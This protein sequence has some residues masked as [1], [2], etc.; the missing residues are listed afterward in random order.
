M[1]K[2]TVTFEK[3]DAVGGKCQAF[4]ESGGFSP[5]GALWFSPPTYREFMKI[6]KKSGVT[7]IPFNLGEKFEYSTADGSLWPRPAPPPAFNALFM[8]EIR[9]Y[10]HWWN[11]YFYLFNTA[12]SYRY[13][14]P[15]MTVELLK[16]QQRRELPLVGESSEELTK[17]LDD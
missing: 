14:T 16:V 11:N 10:M 8:Q 13:L 17:P 15:D 1:G 7:S 2:R 5:L 12:E 9:R 3:K 4:Y 6:V